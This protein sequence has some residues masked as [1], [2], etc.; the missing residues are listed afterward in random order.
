MRIASFFWQNWT[1]VFYS[2]YAQESES[3]I[4][5]IGSTNNVSWKATT[6]DNA[7]SKVN[8]AISLA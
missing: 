2:H 8:N 6:S 3:A 4:L 5:A 7:G 1:Q